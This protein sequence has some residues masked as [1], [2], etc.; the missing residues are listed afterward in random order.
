MIEE[1]L[2][3]DSSA[4]SGT[5]ESQIINQPPGNYASQILPDRLDTVSSFGEMSFA[6]IIFGGIILLVLIFC[7]LKY[8]R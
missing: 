2:V 6:N 5:P 4:P 1:M 3:T 7:G 8:A